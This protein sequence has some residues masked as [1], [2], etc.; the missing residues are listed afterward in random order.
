MFSEGCVP[1]LYLTYV[2]PW[3]VCVAV[4]TLVM[5]S[6]SLSRLYYRFILLLPV[7]SRTS[8]SRTLI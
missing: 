4:L 1:V 8:V 6:Y 7:Y 3:A 2:A 5:V